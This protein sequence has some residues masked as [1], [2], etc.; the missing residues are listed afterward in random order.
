ME[1]LF[2]A[3]RLPEKDNMLMWWTMKSAFS[4]RL[5][6]SRDKQGKK[7]QCWW[8]WG[9]W[10]AGW[11]GW[12]AEDWW[13]VIPLRRNSQALQRT[14]SDKTVQGELGTQELAFAVYCNLEEL[15]F[16]GRTS[17]GFY[18]LLLQ[19]EVWSNYFL[20]TVCRYNCAL[21]LG[22]LCWENN[23]DWINGIDNLLIPL[24]TLFAFKPS[25]FLANL[26]CLLQ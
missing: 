14:F 26:M 18:G 4:R 8:I 21:L 1:H 13:C 22:N 15:C 17:S 7:A 12:R 2:L 6:V 9:Q 10:L 23:Y 19:V 16:S 20:M 11:A 3:W 5:W 24:S 25:F